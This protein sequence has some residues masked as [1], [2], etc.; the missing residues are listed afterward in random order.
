MLCKEPYIIISHV[1]QLYFLSAK[2]KTILGKTFKRRYFEI[3]TGTEHKTCSDTNYG[4]NYNEI[5]ENN[6]LELD[7]QKPPINKLDTQLDSKSSSETDYGNGID[8]LFQNDSLFN[9]TSSYR[10]NNPLSL[11]D[12]DIL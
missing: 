5:F 11:V 10:S 4:S 7:G 2:I 3:R 12:F 1:T 9:S 6:S 8:K